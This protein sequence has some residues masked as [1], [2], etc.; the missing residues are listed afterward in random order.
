MTRITYGKLLCNMKVLFAAL[1]GCMLAIVYGANEP[2]LSLRLDDYNLD[3]TQ[4][5]LVFGMYSI[6]YMIS[7]FLVPYIVPDWVEP[8]VTLITS[9]FL[10]VFSGQAPMT[11]ENG[12][13]ASRKRYYAAAGACVAATGT[14]VAIAMSLV[15]PQPICIAR[16]S[17]FQ[18]F[19]A[20][21]RFHLAATVRRPQHPMQLWFQRRSRPYPMRRCPRR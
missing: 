20:F 2:I 21:A 3:S 13:A 1:T 18:C 19:A 6:F 5:G 14:A 7:T 9:S 11:P 15:R 4:T 10:L 17:A 12:T 16:L 8:R